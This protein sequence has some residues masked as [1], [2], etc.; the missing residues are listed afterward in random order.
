MGSTFALLLP[1][2]ASALWADTGSRAL[3]W[4]EQAASDA[5]DAPCLGGYAAMT[6]YL[7]GYDR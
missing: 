3:V 7:L 5:P 1:L 6:F 4:A 2:S